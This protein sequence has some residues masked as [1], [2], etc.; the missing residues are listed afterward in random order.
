M[1]N[2]PKSRKQ[3]TNDSCLFTKN[4]DR[5]NICLS[6]Q[7]ACLVNKRNK[8][9]SK[10]ATKQTNKLKCTNKQPNLSLQTNLSVHTNKQT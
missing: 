5:N 4:A 7:A 10:Q 8:Q 9:K 6:L 2:K 3:P 1:V